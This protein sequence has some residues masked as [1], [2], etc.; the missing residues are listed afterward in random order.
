MYTVIQL[1]EVTSGPLR[2]VI[3]QDTMGH[4]PDLEAAKEAADN[5]V[6]KFGAPNIVRLNGETV[7]RTDGQ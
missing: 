2:F 4:Y 5:N 6:A 1:Y 7:Y 3:N